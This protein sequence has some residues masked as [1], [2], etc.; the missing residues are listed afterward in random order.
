M[1]SYSKLGLYISN[2]ALKALLLKILGDYRIKIRD[3]YVEEKL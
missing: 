3:S 2:T 1:V